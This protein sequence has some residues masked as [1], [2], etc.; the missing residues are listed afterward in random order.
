M[1][2]LITPEFQT[3]FENYPLYSQESNEDPE[4]IVKLFD[5]Y[6]SATWYLTEYDP[7]DQIAFG[8]VTGLHEDEWGYVSLRELEEIRHPQLGL[9]RIERDRHF[10]QAG[11]KEVVR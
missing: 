9:P 3:A 5:A 8:Y 4:I 10:A 7:N 1:H 6:G 2:H 11:F